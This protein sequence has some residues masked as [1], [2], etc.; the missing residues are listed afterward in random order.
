MIYS[1]MAYKVRLLPPAVEFLDGLPGRLRAKA[2]RAIVLLREFGPYL[3][4]PHSKK[5]SDW[6]GLFE[7]RV[8]L[9]RDN[10]RFFYFWHGHQ[11][12]L[13]TSGYMKKGM[14]LERKELEKAS[15]LMQRY[16]E[17]TGGTHEGD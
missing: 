15:A 2:A 5:V 8:M 9:G 1:C 17:S 16:I 3:R 12:Y 4:E 7:L 6:P 11:V 13:V 10:C 14:K